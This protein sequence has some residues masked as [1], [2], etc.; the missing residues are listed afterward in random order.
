MPKMVIGKIAVLLSLALSGC[1]LPSAKSADSA[2]VAL[3]QQ[4]NVNGIEIMPTKVLEDS[5]C[6]VDAQCI[7]AGR[8]RLQALWL[9]PSRKQQ[10]ELTLGQPLQLADGQLTL[11]SVKPDKLSDKQI[12]PRAYRFAF[13]FDGG[14]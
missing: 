5:R 14:F 11:T 3:G 9:G 6:P 2:H 10:I 4:V 8:V 1:T 7:W 13:D 12:E